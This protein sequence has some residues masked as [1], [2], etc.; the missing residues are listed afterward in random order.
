MPVAVV[1]RL[2]AVEV[3]VQHREQLVAAAHP[4]QG[5]LDLLAELRAVREPG[6][7]V[8]RRLVDQALSRL[9]ALGDIVQ[10][11]D[12]APDA[13]LPAAVGH[14]HLGP[15]QPTGDRP[16]RHLAGRQRPVGAGAGRHQ[17]AERIRSRQS[18]Q[19][20]DAGPY[21]RRLVDVEQLA[22]PRARVGDLLAV[23][24]EHGVV[25]VRD[26]LPQPLSA[27]RQ[28][29]LTALCRDTQRDD[30]ERESADHR[31]DDDSG[32]RLQATEEGGS[33]GL[34]HHRPG[35]VAERPGDDDGVLPSERG[36]VRAPGP[37]RGRTA[38][39]REPGD[40][41]TEQVGPGRPADRPVLVDQEEGGPDAPAELLE[42]QVQAR[43]RE[44]L[45]HREEGLLVAA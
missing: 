44:V 40:R 28:G 1:D 16:A 5:A 33:R 38:R 22:H 18:D 36:P 43:L 31:E 45:V 39:R 19:V 34:E 42:V 17:Q 14:G 4:V 24:D 23:E 6:Q 35:V 13:D 9:A 25:D 8:V 26:Q 32:L 2:E 30:R 37:A 12:G 3:Q 10:R 20:G 21:R 29:P 41:A 11:H 15:D 27:G 7:P